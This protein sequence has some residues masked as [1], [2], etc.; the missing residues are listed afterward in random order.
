MLTNATQRSAGNK[1]K[2]CQPETD[3]IVSAKILGIIIILFIIIIFFATHTF[4]WLL[5]FI[6]VR[7]FLIII[8]YASLISPLHDDTN[9]NVQLNPADIYND[10]GRFYI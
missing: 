6:A 9:A 1:S 4:L 5:S 10:D 2:P 7:I 3:A 8:R